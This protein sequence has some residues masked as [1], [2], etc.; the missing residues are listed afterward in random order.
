MREEGFLT[1][2]SNTP[3]QRKK[4]CVAA[5]EVEKSCTSDH[6]T[7]HL[8]LAMTFHPLSDQAAICTTIQ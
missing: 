7:V 5:G 6:M 4:K 2:G 1:L 8:S 3:N